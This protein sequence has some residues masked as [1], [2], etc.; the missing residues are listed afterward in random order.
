MPLLSPTKRTLLRLALPAVSGFLGMMVY[1]L[2]DIFWIAKLGTVT[3]AGVAAS[4][5]WTWAIEAIMEM[6][7]I[8]CATL[9]AQSIG[10]GKLEGGRRIAREAVHLSVGL[11][12]L[13]VV[14]FYFS[15][16]HL[17]AWMGL[18][19][20]AQVEGWAYIR[21]LILAM[22]LMHLALLG[23]H[24][25]MAHGDVKTAFSILTF[26]L[27]VNALLDPILIFGWFGFPALG[28][29]G[30]AWATVGGLAVGV[31]LRIIFLRRRNFIP[32]LADF[33][34]FTTEYFIRLFQVGAPTAAS[35]LIATTVYPL[36]ATIITG[37]GMA[38]LAGM[39]IA[40]RIES[41]AYFTCLGFS[42]ATATLVGQSVGR[43]DLEGA[44]QTAYEARFLISLILIPV[45]CLFI[46]YPEVLLSFM[47]KDPEAIGNGASYLRTIGY[48]EIF[49]GW[50]FVFEGGF[51][52]L[53][54]TRRY[55]SIS[56]PLT[57]LRF[58]AAL[59]F[60][61]WT[62]NVEAVWWCVSIST[63]LK[64]LMMAGAFGKTRAADLGIASAS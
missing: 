50:E 22:P 44:R 15:M 55:M 17:L 49:L 56:I 33:K 52:G 21:V 14:V 16:P 30:A 9:I 24:I 46:F 2:V 57:L 38:A 32:R 11:S 23:N 62:G 48:F 4:T 6:S 8:G 61:Y 27:I 37:F 42:I 53:G 31:S 10:A 51:N 34:I 35:H 36:L 5:Y 63:L 28:V 29:A 58:P 41:V 19:P 18:S 13:I 7:T 60:V 3:V 64:G 54:S 40:H 1:Q 25:F 47:T 12:S 39:T 43:G 59:L 20:Q 45:S 26:S